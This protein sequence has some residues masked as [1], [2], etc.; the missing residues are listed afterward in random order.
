VT[1]LAWG[2]KRIVDMSREELIDALNEMHRMYM[3]VARA[4][5]AKSPT[6]LGRYDWSVE[7]ADEAM[8]ALFQNPMTD[9]K[10]K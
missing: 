7:E 6:P 4:N 2:L 10:A 3:D 9:V 8:R 1:L 5:M